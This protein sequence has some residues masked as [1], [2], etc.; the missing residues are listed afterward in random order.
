M[1]IEWFNNKSD[2]HRF[3]KQRLWAHVI[4]ES[5][6]QNRD[7]FKSTFNYVDSTL[8]EIVD[9]DLWDKS[10]FY[11]PGHLAPAR[12]AV[13][14]LIL[15]FENIG[16]RSSAHNSSNTDIAYIPMKDIHLFKAQILT[17]RARRWLPNEP[18]KVRRTSDTT[19]DVYLASKKHRSQMTR[20]YGVAYTVIFEVEYKNEEYCLVGVRGERHHPDSKRKVKLSNMD[21]YPDVITLDDEMVEQNELMLH[22]YIPVV[23]VGFDQATSLE[24]I[25]AGSLNRDIPVEPDDMDTYVIPPQISDDVSLDEGQSDPDDVCPDAPWVLRLNPLLSIFGWQ[26]WWEYEYVSGHLTKSNI[27]WRRLNNPPD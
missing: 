19:F 8:L 3:L 9:N 22:L 17:T 7:N 27:C 1:S 2:N 20:R 21:V 5:L 15:G 10:Q 11:I 16:D 4:P 18:A 13:E 25:R 23:V 24:Q 12:F 26:L 6:Y 14:D